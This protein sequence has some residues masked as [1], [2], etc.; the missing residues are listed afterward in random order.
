MTSGPLTRL[1]SVPVS[2]C[3]G[4]F[5]AGGMWWIGNHYASYDPE[6]AG[7]ALAGIFGGIWFFGYVGYLEQVARDDAIT[8]SVLVGTGWWPVVLA[9]WL[10]CGLFYAAYAFSLAFYTWV[11]TGSAE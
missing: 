6:T 11:L 7:K 8:P 1:A 5:V 9:A 10:V 2:L 3:G 4:I